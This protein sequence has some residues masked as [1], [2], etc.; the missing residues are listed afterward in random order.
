[1]TSAG[2]TFLM[3]TSAHWKRKKVLKTLVHHRSCRVCKWWR[4]FRPGLKVKP[5]ACVLNHRGS[6]RSIES[7]A[8]LQAVRQLYQAGTPVDILEGDGDSSMMAKLNEHGYKIKK[9]YDKNHCVKSATTSMYNIKGGR[10]GKTNK[11]EKSLPISKDTISHLEKCLKNALSRYKK[12]PVGLRANLLAIVPHN[13][14]DHSG[15]SP[16]DCGAVRKPEEKYVHKSLPYK[17]PLK[18]LQVKEKLAGIF[19]SLANRAEQLSDLGSSQANEHA[20]K[21]VT[22]RAPKDTHYGDSQSLDWRVNASALFVNEGRSYIPQV[23]MKTKHYLTCYANIC[24][25]SLTPL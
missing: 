23:S 5:H 16:E 3:S 4:K 15:C 12:N 20:N 14:G 1:M 24:S 17:A 13:Y 7:E 8:G 25:K 2:H 18:N 11:G 21:E 10:V 9:K 22:H 6:A 19:T